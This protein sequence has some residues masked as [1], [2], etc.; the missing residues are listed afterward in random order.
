MKVILRCQTNH[1]SIS[2][3]YDV[4]GRS[5]LMTL[6]QVAITSMTVTEPIKRSPGR[7]MS[8]IR[9]EYPSKH[10]RKIGMNVFNS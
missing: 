4:F 2:L 6:I 3:T 7:S 5:P 9:V 1:T 8:T 10:S